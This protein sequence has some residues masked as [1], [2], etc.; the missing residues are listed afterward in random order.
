MEKSRNERTAA[1]REI[2]RRFPEY[3][4]LVRPLPATAEDI[5]A[6]LRPEEALLS[7][8]FGT[9]SSFVWAV[10][11][12]G[13]IA[14]AALRTT[15]G[16]MDK[17]VNSLRAPFEAEIATI[18]A[19]PA[20][21]VAAAH[22]LYKLLLEPVAEVWR[23]AKNLI[24]VTNGALGLLPLSLLPVAPADVNEIAGE[25]YFAA[26]RRVAWLARTHAVVSVPSAS[27]LRTLRSATAA[28]AKRESF[29]GFA[30]PIFSLDQ[31]REAVPTETADVDAADVRGV[32]VRV[33]ASPRLGQARS[34][35]LGMLP[36]LPDTADELK[37]VALALQVDPAKVL[38]LGKAANEKT[39]KG[40]DLSRYRIVAFSTH[41]LV[42]GDLDGLAEPAA[43]GARGC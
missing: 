43:D 10:R 24:V 37:S 8:Y 26:Y 30:D 34:A 6:A 41:G 13:P 12:D 39:V 27:A 22:D 23:P 20:F 31:M 38:H 1:K 40:L 15:A 19:I 42:P 18:G 5:R 25:P 17:K 11:K 29:I 3:A 28:P 35:T 14:F 32:R 21:D 2:D 4:N 9:R 16:D 36:R 33:R 7:F